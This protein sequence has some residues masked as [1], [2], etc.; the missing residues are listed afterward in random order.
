MAENTGLT[1]LE[2]QEIDSN[3]DEVRFP[4]HLSRFIN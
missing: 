4:C 3:W 1:D 2:G